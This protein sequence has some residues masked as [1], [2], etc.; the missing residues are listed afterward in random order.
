MRR[1]ARTSRQEVDSREARPSSWRAAPLVCPRALALDRPDPA[2]AR[3][4]WSR[5]IGEITSLHLGKVIRD[6]PP[7]L[8]E[9][10]Q[11]V[12]DS[13]LE[14]ARHLPE[15]AGIRRAHVVQP[16]GVE[17]EHVAAVVVGDLRV[18]PLVLE[19]LG[20]LEPP[21]GF[22]L[23]LGRAVPEGIGAEM[24]SECDPLFLAATA[25]RTSGAVAR[26]TT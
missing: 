6:E 18:A 16:R 20:D 14:I 21:E 3:V 17:A 9:G 12:G 25:V 13:G 1:W 24:S 11:S 15:A 10:L 8:E 19:L 22:D 26:L 4:V 5:A 7:E 2:V 23:P